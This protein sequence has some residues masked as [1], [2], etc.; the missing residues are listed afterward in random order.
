MTDQNIA[1]IMSGKLAQPFGSY[2]SI[3]RDWAA[4]QPDAVAL[5][6]DDGQLTWAELVDQVER[7]AARMIETGLK[8]G[9]S[10]AI[11]G[12][13]SIPY[14]LV[15][16]AAMRAGGVAAPLTTS[17]S[18]E[19]LAGMAADSGAIHLF[20]DARKSAE[21]DFDFMADLIRVPL[22]SIGTWMAPS[23][24]HAPDF[25]PQPSD[26]FNIIYSSGT[27]G[28]PKG[29][30]HS[31]QMRWRQFGATALSYLQA[32]LEVRSLASTPLY[33]NTTMVAFLAALLA[34]GTVRVMGKFDCARWLDHAAG[35]RT[36]VT[37]LVPVQYQRLMDHAGFDDHDLSS[38]AMKYCTSAPFVAKLKAEVLRRMPGGLVEIYSMTEGGVVCLLAAHEFPDKLHT[39]GRPAPGSEMKVLDDEDREVSPGTPGNL[40]GRS[41]TMMSGYKNRP[42]KT[43]EAQWTDPETG[44]VWMRMGDIGRVDEQGFV[45][46]V[47]RAKDMIISGGFNIYPSDLEGELGREGDV[48]E[49]AV[50]GIDSS[51]WGE[52]PVGF[53]VLRDGAR[54][55]DSIMAAVNARLGKTQRLSALHTIDEMPR[56]HIG[57]LLKTDLRKEAVRRA[58]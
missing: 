14:A 25:D 4:F 33:S 17:A 26:P 3:L 32:G 37:M 46:L 58:E 41:Q 6:D 57:K 20:I 52:T 8:R 31:H 1:D 21:L 50:V 30:V 29:I 42:D 44:D 34:G 18:P 2:P 19:Q 23:G 48:A 43:A 47:G 22:E 36:T 10:V 9:Q 12:T 54:D 51:R 24:S 11:L 56:S 45:E 16:L 7:L 53:V 35:D 49:A 5:I 38:L 28:I 39:V 55:T 13:S 40:V 15:F 27:T